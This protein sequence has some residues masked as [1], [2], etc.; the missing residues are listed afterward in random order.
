M[1]WKNVNEKL[2]FFIYASSAIGIIYTFIKYLL[3][4]SFIIY[5]EQLVSVPFLLPYNQYFIL[6][7]IIPF[8]VF[9]MY[10]VWLIYR[11][12][13]AK[14]IPDSWTTLSFLILISLPMVWSAT[15]K[16]LSEPLPVFDLLIGLLFLIPVS[17]FITKLSFTTFKIILE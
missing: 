14:S 13:K 16:L 9:L 11:F 12:F 15:L 3:D 7:I 4:N 5:K 2:K 8:I 17:L 10:I 1:T 6:G